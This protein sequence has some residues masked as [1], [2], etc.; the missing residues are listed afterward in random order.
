LHH[1]IPPTV[2]EN[3]NTRR[4][5]NHFRQYQFRQAADPNTPPDTPRSKKETFSTSSATN[6]A[7]EHRTTH[8]APTRSLDRV[9]LSLAPDC[10]VV[11]LRQE[12]KAIVAKR[13]AASHQGVA[14]II[15]SEPS[16]E[17]TQPVRTERSIPACSRSSAAHNDTPKHAD[18]RPIRVHT[19]EVTGSIPVSPTM[20]TPGQGPIRFSSGSVPD[21][22]RD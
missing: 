12:Q 14:M 8:P 6:M 16:A 11:G 19:E 4:I 15:V 10:R 7:E 2:L 22:V 17:A 5:A 21:L 18:A 3:N 13:P 20:K 9:D 1:N